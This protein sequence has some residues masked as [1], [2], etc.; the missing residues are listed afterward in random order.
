MRNE[1]YKQRKQYANWLSTE[2]W[3]YFFTGTFR[4]E[5]I[6]ANGAR[7]A[8]QRFFRGFTTKELIVLFIESGKLY[9]KVHLHG[10]LRFRFDQRPTAQTIWKRW[11][12]KYGRARVE[13]IESREAVSNYCCKYVTKQMKD[14]TFIVI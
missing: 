13:T 2:K 6:S 7:R 4:F 3:D 1:N 5:D 14:E 11:F 9:G 12:D 8:A 10:L